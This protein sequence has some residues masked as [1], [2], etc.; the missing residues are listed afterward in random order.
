MCSS[1]N[2]LKQ[3]KLEELEDSCRQCCS[4][5]ES[6]EGKAVGKSFNLN[7]NNFFIV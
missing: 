2:E 3:F 1:C 5:D 6:D 4:D 7:K